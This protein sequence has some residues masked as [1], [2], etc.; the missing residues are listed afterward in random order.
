VRR[1]DFNAKNEQQNR[2]K[3]DQIFRPFILIGTISLALLAGTNAASAADTA[4]LSVTATGTGL[5]TFSPN[6]N[7]KSLIID[8]TYTIRA[9]PAPGCEFSE[10]IVT[11][12]NTTTNTNDK[13]TF[14][15]VSGLELTAVFSD[16]KSPTLKITTKSATVS[17]SV[18]GIIGTAKDNVGVTSVWWQVGSG[19]WNRATSS[20]AYTNWTAIAI[21]NAGANAVNFYAEDAAENRS[22]TNTVTLTDDSTA[23]AADSVADTRLHVVTTNDESVVMSF[24]GSTFSFLGSGGAD[25]GVGVYT[26]SMS[27]ANTGELALNFTAP[28]EAASSESTTNIITLSFTNIASGTF[29]NTKGN[30]GSFSLT[31]ESATA[32]ASLSG[33]TL[34]GTNNGTNVFQFTNVYGDGTFAG[35]STTGDSSGTYIYAKYSPSV[36]LAQVLYTNAADLGTTNYVVLNFSAATNTFYVESDYTNGTSTNTGAFSAAGE[37]SAAGYTA[38]ASLEGLTGMV[39]TIKNDK[40]KSFDISFGASTFGQFTAKAGD[41]D[42]SAGSYTYTRTGTKTGQLVIDTLTPPDE[43]TNAGISVIP[44]YFSSSHS[45]SFTNSGGSDN[46]HGTITLMVPTSTVPLS[47]VGRELKGGSG[48]FAFGYNSFNGIGHNSTD[49]GTYTYAIYGPQVAMATMN[50]TAGKDSGT[51]YLELWF[52]SGT[53]GSYSQDDGTGKINTGTFTMK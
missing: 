31:E 16:V 11:G 41:G 40:R 9:I 28:P 47:L 5:G 29:T 8:K 27:D 33:W 37:T 25:T 3:L 43:V 44:L 32:P 30:S 46:S 36:G 2:M 45:V 7:G 20:D 42:T 14:Q 6:D 24:S 50:F 38:P 19:G 35:T 1:L 51:E 23:L 21:L 22:P 53:G 12:T 52:S 39:T 4:T 18:V 15:M 34:Q 10:W 13:L 48:G 17:N 26:Y 49:M